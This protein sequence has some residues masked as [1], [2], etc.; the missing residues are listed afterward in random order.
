MES[1]SPLMDLMYFPVRN[2]C[3]N[4]RCGYGDC[5][6]N[7]KKYPYYECKCKPPF[8]GPNCM[9]CESAV[10][11]TCQHRQKHI[12]LLCLRQCQ[13][14]PASPILAKMEPPA[15]KEKAVSTALAPMGTLGS[16]VKLVSHH[17]PNTAPK[18]KPV[19]SNVKTI[20]LHSAF[21][22]FFRHSSQ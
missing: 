11:L 8:Q 6:V 7:L 3:E 15:S 18:S 14:R 12:T 20:R 2:L 4:V 9:T 16:S 22:G 10:I 1:V 21:C 13:R 19:I 5:V 17:S